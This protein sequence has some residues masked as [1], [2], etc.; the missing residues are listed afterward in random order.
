MQGKCGDFC[1]EEAL[2]L[3]FYLQHNVKLVGGFLLNISQGFICLYTHHPHRTICNPLGELIDKF[4]LECETRVIQIDGTP[5][6]DE[7]EIIKRT[8]M[9]RRIRK[10]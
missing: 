9:K 5:V 2:C 1:V 8:S 10:N 3:S 6:D 7:K 4:P